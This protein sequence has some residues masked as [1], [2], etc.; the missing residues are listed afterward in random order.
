MLDKN[1]DYQKFEAK[2]Y[3]A[4][5]ESGKFAPNPAAEQCYT[6]ALPPPNVTGFLHVGHALNHTLQ[7]ILIRYHRMRGYATLW[8]PGTD[9][10][11]I[12]TQMMVERDLM[13]KG[14]ERRSIGREKFVQHVWDWKHEY[15]GRIVDQQRRL[16]ESCDWSRQRFTMDEGLSQAVIKVFVQLHQEGLIY[17]D[18]RLVNWD[19]QLQTAVSDL[20]VENKTIAGKLYHLRYCFVDG[21]IDG[22]EGIEVATTRPETLFGDAAVAV[23][24]QDERYAHLIGKSVLLPITQ[25]AIPIIADEH[26]DPT[27]GSGAVKITPAHDFNDFEVGKRHQLE[28]IAVID[29]QG[30]LNEN[31]P[32]DY[33]G[34][35]RSAAREKLLDALA[36]EGLLIHTDE[37]HHSVPH[38]D[39]SKTIL[40]PLLTEQWFLNAE[41]LAQPAIKAV[42]EGRIQIIP[43]TERNRYFSWMRDIQPWCISR[44][45][46]WGHQ[47]PAWY[48]PDGEIFVAE[49]EPQAR[50]LAQQHYGQDTPLTRDPDVL[51]TWFSSALWPFSTLGWPAPAPHEATLLQ[52][53]YPND[54]L[55]TGSD[56]LFF[57]VARMI[58]LG[59]HFMHDVPFHTV[60]LHG[61]VRDGQ[62]RKMSKT[63]GNVINPMDLCDS[64]G[65]DATRL[66]L[67]ALTVQGR[68]AKL[69]DQ[70]LEGYRHFITKLWN[71]SRFFDHHGITLERDAPCP[72]V[73]A[74]HNQWMLDNLVQA[75]TE[76]DQALAEYR[77]NDYAQALYR[78]VWNRFCDWYIELIKPILQDKTHLH[79]AETLA[80]AQYSLVCMLKLLHP[81]TPFVTEELLH[82][83]SAQSETHL[84]DASWPQKSDI[85]HDTQDT[86]LDRATIDWLC[87]LIA[88]IR[89]MKVSMDIAPASAVAINLACFTQEQQQWLELYRDALHTLARVSL[90]HTPFPNVVRF[91]HAGLM[92][93]LHLSDHVDL[94]AVLARLQK[95]QQK[96]QKQ[97]EQTQ[98]RLN[99]ADFVARAP[100]EVLEENRARLAEMQQTLTQYATLV[101]ALL[102]R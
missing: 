53:H 45:L 5:E 62:G 88:T 12:A 20:E 89:S 42:E 3:A 11:G 25:R 54:V 7:D 78:L 13:A 65:A 18:Q 79:H 72:V 30:L 15:G 10:A 91:P 84:I 58:M 101:K 24:P 32:E 82:Q 6:I 33:R 63:L 52:R 2:H 81:V 31:A 61:L 97:L 76:V 57:W 49:T 74:A 26:A 92:V 96:C 80:C 19:V 47:I 73:H 94:V 44:Q 50:T 43:E 95:E 56:I 35:E 67:C 77:F 23:H 4:W 22:L 1:F 46:W 86:T 59:L 93:D 68:D 27:Q 29:K 51:D 100:T 14:I 71:A 69:S 34:M 8:Q 28:R 85:I 64:K 40:E 55:I 37:H 75:I 41:H 102:S 60:F 90:D 38:G 9:H 66:T 48:G 16:G 70:R 99:N 87:H 83:L 39:R 36:Q 21:P 17:R 98:N